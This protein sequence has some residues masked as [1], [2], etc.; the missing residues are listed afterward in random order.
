MTITK[1]G[2]CCLIVDVRGTRFLTDPG[3]YTTAQNTVKGIHYI[4]ISHEHTDHLHVE[5]LKIV[6]ANN[7]DAKVISNEVVGKILK[8][9]SIPYIK[10]DDGDKAT[11]DGVT[12]AGYGT[13]HAHI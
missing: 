7:P 6:L 13:R 1:L 12:I 5:S 9:E 3:A 2:H 11:F 8:K 4:V 10:I